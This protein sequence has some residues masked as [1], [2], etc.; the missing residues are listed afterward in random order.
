[1]LPV[2]AG[3]ALLRR[4]LR[5]QL[6]RRRPRRAARDAVDDLL[7]DGL[8]GLGHV[9]VGLGRRLDEAHVVLG[10]E[11][12]ALLQR[13]LATASTGG[14]FK[15]GCRRRTFKEPQTVLWCR[16]LLPPSA[17]GPKAPS[18]KNQKKPASWLTGGSPGGPGD[19][20]V[21]FHY[22][23]NRLCRRPSLPGPPPP[24]SDARAVP[25]F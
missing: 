2:S 17:C 13:K 12:L 4:L 25:N 8:E 10:G 5:G 14:S 11:R 22:V 24:G 18:Q 21:R 15:R 9:D 23:R 6:A 3:A 20:C 16:Y 19:A 7:R 1:M